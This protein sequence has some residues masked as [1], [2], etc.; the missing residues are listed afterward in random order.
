MIE[1]EKVKRKKHI[2]PLTPS[3]DGPLPPTVFHLPT[4]SPLPPHLRPFPLPHRAVV[5]EEQRGAAGEQQG[6]GAQA[7]PGIRFGN[8][9]FAKEWNIS[10]FFFLDVESPPVPSVLG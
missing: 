2:L 6:E 3:P 10:P 4:V 1:T 8:F 7:E 9:F 5:Q